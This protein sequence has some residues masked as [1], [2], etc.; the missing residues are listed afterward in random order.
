[1][2]QLQ[3][4][5]VDLYRDVQAQEK[6]DKASAAAAKK[7]QG[8]GAAK[9]QV[10]WRPARRGAV[11]ALAFSTHLVPAPLT[12]MHGTTVVSHLNPASAPLAHPSWTRSTSQEADGAT[13]KPARAAKAGTSGIYKV[14]C[15]DNG[16]GMHHK[17]IPN[18][19]GRVL[20]GTKYGVKQTRGKFGLGAKM[21]LL[22]CAIAPPGVAALS[23]PSLPGVV[24]VTGSVALAE[25]DDGRSGTPR[26]GHVAMLRRADV[27]WHIPPPARVLTQCM[28]A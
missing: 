25:M 16:Q 22:W 17:D 9:V 10:L 20:S 8:K 3:R 7:A 4:R 13:A 28:R 15:R 27:R 5:D 24:L 23:T 21:A 19:L 14:T 2:E 18:M 12:A 11:Y 6:A 26:M 1:M